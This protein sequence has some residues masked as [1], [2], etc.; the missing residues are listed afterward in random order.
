MRAGVRRCFEAAAAAFAEAVATIGDD[1]WD[2]PGLGEWTVRDLVGH[3]SRSLTTIE[4]Y[5]AAAS[6]SPV[7]ITI[8]DPV[9]Y[10]QGAR[11]MTAA[12]PAAIAQRGRDAGAALGAD[13]EARRAMVQ[14][15]AERVVAL[16]AATPDDAP[17]AMP[18]GGAL[19]IAYL[20]T[21]TFELTVHTL[22]LLAALGNRAVPEGLAEPVAACLQLAVA[23]AGHGSGAAPLLLALT[24]R[25]ALAPG[26]SVI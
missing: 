11:Q 8:Q 15:L 23:A 25:R 18:F 24:G 10:L 7:A 5:L 2:R 13:P 16:V 14:A 22:D 6:G 20:P 9:E 21:R 26:F 1:Q 12:D 3:A 17:V 4:T 19:L